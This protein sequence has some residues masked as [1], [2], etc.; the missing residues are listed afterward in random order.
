MADTEEVVEPLHLE[1][2]DREVYL[3]KIPVRTRVYGRV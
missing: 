3:A 1:L 2:E